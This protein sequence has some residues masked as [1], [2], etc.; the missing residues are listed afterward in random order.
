MNVRIYAAV[1][2]VLVSGH[3]MACDCTLKINKNNP[4]C[5]TQPT[6]PTNG[7]G[8]TTSTSNS[9]SGAVA[10]AASAAQSAASVGNTTAGGGTGYGGTAS[11]VSGSSG[12]NSSGNS[13]AFGGPSAATINEG[14]SSYTYR[15]SAN[16]VQPATMV[17]TG[18]QVQGQVGGSNTRAAG[19]LGIG[20]TPKSCYDYIQAQ[21]FL[22]AGD[23]EA[24]CEI[25]HHTEA[26]RRAVKDGAVLPP[27]HIVAPVPQ[28]LAPTQ[29]MYTAEEVDMLMRKAIRK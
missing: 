3:A 12:V 13:S 6:A 1:A 29:R 15:E 8:Q 5:K 22:A 7:N 27:C 16:V 18:C 17:I 24:A 26:A 10:G 23:R 19:M 2:A 9:T 28:N 11:A 20:F 21:A 14:S 4:A 25:L